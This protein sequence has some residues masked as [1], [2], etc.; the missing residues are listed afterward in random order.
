MGAHGSR[1]VFQRRSL[2]REPNHAQIASSE[3]LDLAENEKTFL[4]PSEAGG[5]DYRS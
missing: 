2:D 4:I 3:G 5:Q 1:K